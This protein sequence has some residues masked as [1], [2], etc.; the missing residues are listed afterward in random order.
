MRCTI[1]IKLLLVTCFLSLNAS[2]S[3]IERDYLGVSGG[4][5]YDSESELEWLDLTFTR[6]LDL[7]EYLNYLND[8][9]AEWKFASSAL[10]SQLLTNFNF[11]FDQS[12]N[13]IYGNAIAYNGFYTHSKP[14]PSFFDHIEEL[15]M[16]GESMDSASKFYGIKGFTSDMQGSYYEQYM[17]YYTTSKKTGVVS[18]GDFI[19]TPSKNL[20]NSFFT[21]RESSA[22]QAANVNGPT[23][24]SPA[25]A[26]PEP[27]TLA[28]FSMFLCLMGLRKIKNQAKIVLSSLNYS[29]EASKSLINTKLIN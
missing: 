28:L 2:A 26:V 3:L 20:F 13:N 17:A 15:T 16:L 7:T 10:V 9:D 8:L 4:I 27:A 25:I 1:F 22:L 19:R 5:T 23:L 12:D 14:S 6:N 11:T 21:Y 29:I 18:A 24:T